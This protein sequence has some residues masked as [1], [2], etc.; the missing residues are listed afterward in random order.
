MYR[1]QNYLNSLIG[2][3]SNAMSA[4]VASAE[5]DNV[6][7]KLNKLEK[8]LSDFEFSTLPDGIITTHGTLVGF[9]NGKVAVGREGASCDRRLFNNIIHMTYFNE[10]NIR[11]I[12][13]FIERMDAR[14]IAKAT[15]IFENFLR[16]L[17]SYR[18][19]G[20]YDRETMSFESKMGMHISL[21]TWNGCDG[22]WAVM[23]HKDGTVNYRSLFVNHGRHEYNTANDDL[24]AKNAARIVR[25]HELTELGYHGRVEMQYDKCN[26]KNRSIHHNC[27]CTEE[28]TIR[29]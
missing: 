26:H 28:I 7:R 19:K 10:T 12:S 29:R 20:E 16:V 25:R 27:G 4:K 8:S 21:Q 15:P 22:V 18:I 13:S 6:P 17:V 14:Q 5:L 2:N 9:V 1:D 3:T 24:Y 23:T 11:G